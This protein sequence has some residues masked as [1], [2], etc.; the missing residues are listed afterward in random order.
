MPL[1]YSCMPLMV[2]ILKFT[3]VHLHYITDQFTLEF[4]QRQIRGELRI[5]IHRFTQANNKYLSNY[6]T[7]KTSTS[8]RP[9]DANYLY[10]YAISQKLPTR[11]FHSFP[12][13][14][15]QQYGNNF[16]L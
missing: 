2:A 14:E 4:F 16:I 5:A 3:K 10:G 7:A 9:V 13:P 15:S 6:N 12:L 8:L 11:T 1:V